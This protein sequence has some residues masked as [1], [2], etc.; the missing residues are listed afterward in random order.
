MVFDPETETTLIELPI[1]VVHINHILSLQIEPSP[2]ITFTVQGRGVIEFFARQL[3]CKVSE[4][5]IT[6]NVEQSLADSIYKKLAE[7]QPKKWD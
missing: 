6:L 2:G 7:E 1:K 3:G 4:I 5:T